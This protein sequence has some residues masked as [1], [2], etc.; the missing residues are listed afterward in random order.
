MVG[1]KTITDLRIDLFAVTDFFFVFKL[2]K[3]VG[4]SAIRIEKR[5]FDAIYFH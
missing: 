4:N 5:N 2:K 1:P 3:K